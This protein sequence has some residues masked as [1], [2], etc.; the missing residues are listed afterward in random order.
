MLKHLISFFY[1]NTSRGLGSCEVFQTKNTNT[2]FLI[3][4]FQES[5]NS[6]Q[7]NSSTAA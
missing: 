6:K 5:V 1:F 4:M 2:L 7:C 3:E